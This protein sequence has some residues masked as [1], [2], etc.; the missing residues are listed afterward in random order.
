MDRRMSK[1]YEER[2]SWTLSRA[3]NVKYGIRE[4]VENG[5][6]D[7]HKLHSILNG[8]N[9]VDLHYPAYIEIFVPVGTY[10]YTEE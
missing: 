9:N 1:Y 10:Y 3:H 7:L 5:S 4:N 6:R 8:Q 2:L